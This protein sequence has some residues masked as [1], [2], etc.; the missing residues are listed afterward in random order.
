MNRPVG[1]PLGRPTHGRERAREKIMAKLKK[2][3]LRNVICVRVSDRER[4]MLRLVA[5]QKDQKISQVMRDVL[6]HQFLCTSRHGAC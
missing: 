3:N 1:R 5:Q 4:A 2:T 6:F